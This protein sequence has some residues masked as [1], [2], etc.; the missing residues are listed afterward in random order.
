MCVL[1]GTEKRHFKLYMSS[2]LNVLSNLT[3]QLRFHEQYL[4]LIALGLC[5]RSFKSQIRPSQPQNLRERYL[6][7]FSTDCLET[8]N[9]NSLC[10]Y[11]GHW[12]KKRR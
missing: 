5:R 9:M 8:E 3:A 1:K 6:H 10:I 12:L 7:Q 2:R 4:Q 11:I